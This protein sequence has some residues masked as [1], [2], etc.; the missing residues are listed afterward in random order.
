MK[1]ARIV[2]QD[3]AE[4]EEEQQRKR[5]RKVMNEKMAEYYQ[6]VKENFAVN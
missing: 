4:A 1:H 3:L 6:Y 2:E 5:Q